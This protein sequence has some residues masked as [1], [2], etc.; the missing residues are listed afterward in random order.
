MR[1][2]KQSPLGDGQWRLP[3]LLSC[4]HP[5]CC[6]VRVCV[7]LCFQVVG[8]GGFG[9]VNAITKLDTQEL[10]ALKRME[11]Y[12]VLQSSSHLK[13]VW[14]ERKIMSLTNS[15]FLCNLLHA[16]ESDK[17]L[18]LVMPFMQVETH[19][20]THTHASTPLLSRSR[21]RRRR[22][23]GFAGL[24]PACCLC[25]R[26]LCSRCLPCFCFCFCRAAICVST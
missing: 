15:P 4:S 25:V 26:A 9:K 17:E 11:K 5:V 12:A 14:I 19:T 16:F 24:T 7:V 18:Y 8:K 23:S 10:M 6:P 13:M 22:A 1:G 20:R 21:M 2:L 3:S